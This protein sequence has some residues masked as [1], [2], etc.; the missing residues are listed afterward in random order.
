MMKKAV[1]LT[2]RDAP[3]MTVKGR[4]QIAAWL[5]RQ[6]DYL[7]EHYSELHNTFRASY[8]YEEDKRK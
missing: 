3:D 4:K 5:K 6:A 7:L 2:I 8:Y 1:I